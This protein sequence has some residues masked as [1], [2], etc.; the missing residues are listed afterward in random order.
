MDE[1]YR[2][3]AGSTDEEADDISSLDALELRNDES[4]EY[5][6]DGLYGEKDADPV[7]CSLI[8]FSKITILI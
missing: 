1:E 2:C 7:S 6:S 4:P 8:T 5:R 3:E